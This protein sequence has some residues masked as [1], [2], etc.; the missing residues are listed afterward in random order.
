MKIIQDVPLTD[1]SQDKFGRTALVELIVDSIN[2]VVSDQHSYIVYGIFG[3][4][5]EGKTSLMNFVKNRLKNQNTRKYSHQTDT[6]DY[7]VFNK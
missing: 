6:T 2:E 5:G 3:K 7:L 4:W 1:I